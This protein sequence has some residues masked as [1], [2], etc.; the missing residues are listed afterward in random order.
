MLNWLLVLLLFWDLFLLGVLEG[1]S[2]DSLLVV[3]SWASAE[4][5]PL[6]IRADT[7][8]ILI[9]TRKGS[10]PAIRSDSLHLHDLGSTEHVGE[11]DRG[12]VFLLVGHLSLYTLVRED[13]VDSF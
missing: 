7:L 1:G 6:M 4:L 11:L 5:L 2:L 9:Q 13:S 12:S 3:A 10:C 8:S